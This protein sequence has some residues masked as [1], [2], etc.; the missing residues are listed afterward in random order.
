MKLFSKKLFKYKFLALSLFTFVEIISFITIFIYYKPMYLKTFEQINN[1]TKEKV[2]N[3]T[4]SIN[5]LFE[6]TFS[7]HYLDLRFVGKHMSFFANSDINNNSKFYQKLK[8]D[9]DKHIIFGKLEDLKKNLSKYY[10]DSTEKF[11][12][13]EKYINNYMIK[14]K[15]NVN[16]LVDLMNNSLHPELNYISFYKPYNSINYIENNQIKKTAAKYLISIL[17]TNFLNRL[18][19]KD[20]NNELIH[21]ILLS[22][23]EIYIY[24]P[25][26]INNTIIYSLI[27]SYN[28][29]EIFP[30]CFYD[31]ISS[32]MNYIAYYYDAAEYI[33]PLFPY[34]ISLGE[35]LYF[36]LCISIPLD[37]KLN[38]DDLHYSPKICVEL[39]TTK[40]FQKGFFQ[41]KEAF[42]FIF[43]IFYSSN[44]EKK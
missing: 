11:C 16:I 36:V 1:I 22:Y 43:L 3:I 37:E 14:T 38:S 2:M 25:D 28:C 7:R 6:I 39:N 30:F 13:L 4:D 34:T 18:V 27:D 20:K 8:K 15:D 35:Y 31:D 10:D 29:R 9:E 26:A 5:E 44:Q 17:K 23:D 19:T 32:Y 12:Y 21:Y 42:H 40:I 24:P 33:F 41:S